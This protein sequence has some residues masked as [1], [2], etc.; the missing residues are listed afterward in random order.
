MRI[1]IMAQN[2]TVL[3]LEKERSN[4]DGCIGKLNQ[5]ATWENLW[6]KHGMPMEWVAY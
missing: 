3:C 4:I 5:I 1:S 6:L 2:W